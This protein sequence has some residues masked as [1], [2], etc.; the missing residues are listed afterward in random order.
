MKNTLKL[1]KSQNQDQQHLLKCEVLLRKLQSKQILNNCPEYENIYSPD[2]IKQKE[3]TS[4]YRE[5]FMIKNEI[6]T[7]DSQQAPSTVDMVLVNNDNLR[8]SIVHQSPGK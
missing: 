5:L 4:L 7:E 6:E 8:F 2:I 1:K 3:I